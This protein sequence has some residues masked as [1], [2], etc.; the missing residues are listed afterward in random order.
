MPTPFTI[1]VNEDETAW[2]MRRVQD[3][4]FFSEPEDAGWRYGANRAYLEQL[5]DYWLSG[6]DWPAAVKSLNRHP[7]VRVNIE[8]KAV[9]PGFHLHTVHR[10]SPRADAKPLLIAHGWPGSIFE[11]D[12][13][14]D[15]LADPE[16]DSHP[17][18]HVVAPSL[19]G[20][21]WSDPPLSPIGP[22]SVAGL[23]DRLM[24]ALGYEQ[25]IYQGGDWGS[26]IGGW[27]GLDSRRVTA[28]HLNGYGLR[29]HD[30]TPR[31]DEDKKWMQ[32]ALKIRAEETAYLQLQATKPQSLAYRHDGQPD[33]R[34]RL[35]R[36]EILRLVGYR[37][38]ESPAAIHQRPDA[39]QH[40]DLPDDAQLSHR[41]V[42]VPRHVRGGRI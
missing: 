40:H 32:W 7:Q 30:M 39:H 21:A 2:I 23:Y 25:Y 10:R 5:R 11:F 35:A 15:R 17:A 38:A 26:V 18:F 3:F 6:F 19:P 34:R 4:R 1:P 31:S 28:L 20:Y 14:I 16:D 42:A 29:A 13:I 37:R 24:P 41:D 8:D 22:R 12:A 27:I 9:P 33:G 36:R